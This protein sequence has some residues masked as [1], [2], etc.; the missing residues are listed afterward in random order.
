MKLIIDGVSVKP[1][2]LHKNKIADVYLTSMQNDPMYCYMFQ[3]ISNHEKYLFA[4]WKALVYYSFV[5]GEV[6]TTKDLNAGACWLLPGK[7]SFTLARIVISKF[8]LPLA[9]FS[10]PSLARNRAMGIFDYLEKVQ[11]NCIAE[12]HYYLMVLGVSPQ[13]QG[14]GIGTKLIEPVLQRADALGYKCYLETE[15]EI[16]I[17]F[18]EKNGFHVEREFIVPRHGIKFWAMIRNPKVK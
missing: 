8:Q 18:Y 1:E 2:P 13:M 14:K 15:T 6:H 12:P 7:C 16:N 11:R 10:F 9:L 3:D 5:N 17:K 4:F